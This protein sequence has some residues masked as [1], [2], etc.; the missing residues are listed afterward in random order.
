MIWKKKKYDETKESDLEKEKISFLKTMNQRMEARDKNQKSEDAEDRY[1]ATIAHKLR[2]LQY[3]ERLMAKHEIENMLHKFQMQAL[4]KGNVYTI[5]ASSP[6][7]MGD[8]FPLLQFP[9]TVLSP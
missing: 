4:E 3:R 2:E 6:N 9:M 5:Q 7:N 1:V 8:N